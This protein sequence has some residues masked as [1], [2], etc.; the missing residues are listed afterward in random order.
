MHKSIIALMLY[1]SALQLIV[2]V[3]LCESFVCSFNITGNS[4]YPK[5]LSI[6]AATFSCQAGTGSNLTASLPVANNAAL[7][8]FSTSFSGKHLVCYL[9][10]SML[11]YSA[12][13]DDALAFFD[14]C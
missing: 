14:D 1:L 13:A 6:S 5:T 7:L 10:P 11:C 9:M 3:A 2:D 8:P 12:Q 4:V